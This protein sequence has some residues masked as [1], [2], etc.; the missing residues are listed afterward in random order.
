MHYWAI[1]ARLKTTDG[2]IM[3]IAVP[4]VMY[5]YPQEV[6][7][8][9]VSFELT[10][11]ENKSEELQDL[12]VI[13][14]NEF[15]ES[16][17]GKHIDT[18]FDGIVTWTLVPMN[19]LHVHPGNLD[20]FSMT[21]YKKNASNP[22]ICFP[23]HDCPP[24]TASFSSIMVHSPRTHA[25]KLVRT[26]FRTCTIS[27][28]EIAYSHGGCVSIVQANTHVPASH[29]L[30]NLISPAVEEHDVDTSYTF[31]DRLEYAP[32]EI[33][34]EIIDLFKISTFRPDVA[35]IMKKNIK[36]PFDNGYKSNRYN[37]P[38]NRG[39]NSRLDQYRPQRSLM[40]LDEEDVDDLEESTWM[41][42]SEEDVSTIFPYEESD[43]PDEIYI[44]RGKIFYVNTP[45]TPDM[46]ADM[47]LELYQKNLITQAQMANLTMLEIV[48]RY[49][50]TYDIETVIAAYESPSEV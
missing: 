15:M 48:K 35:H 44:S 39:R 42:L 37:N 27:E 36:K 34:Q 6:S 20:M 26:E 49:D 41:D 5:N 16:P 24:E 32:G 11:V 33:M 2:M 9:S 43:A 4:V 17:L 50:Q 47:Q 30:M 7:S 45:L 28:A 25:P 19:T 22:G 3:D 8:G 31:V 23:I 38:Y 10:D 29:P 40:E 18:I 14:A 13:K 21:D 46:I 1:T 12:A